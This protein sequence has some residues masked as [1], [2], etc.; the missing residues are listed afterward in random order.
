MIGY[1]NAGD[2]DNNPD[3][4][5]SLTWTK[6][7]VSNNTEFTAAYPVTGSPLVSDPSKMLIFGG[8]T[9][10]TFLLDTKQDINLTN[11]T[12][13]VTTYPASLAQT[14][15][16]ANKCDFTGATFGFNHYAIDAATKVLHVFKEKSQQWEAQ[17]L[18]SLGIEK[19]KTSKQ[20]VSQK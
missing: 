4:M 2:I 19:I 9:N 1:L 8:N 15:R 6:L 3:E 7:W 16:F 18:N 20:A 17:G 13:K 10:Q 11:G 5:A 12:A 14:A